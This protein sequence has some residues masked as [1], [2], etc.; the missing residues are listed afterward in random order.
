MH[1]L[2]RRKGVAAASLLMLAATALTLTP[3]AAQA[4]P[5]PTAPAKRGFRLFARS[6]GALTINRVYCGLSSVGNI[7]VDSTNSTTVGGGF[8]PKGTPNQ[9]IFNTGLQLAGIIG[10][11]KATNPWGADTTGAFF[12]DATGFF[13]SGREVAPIYNMVQP[14]DKAAVEAGATDQTKAAKVPTELVDSLN[15]FNPVL[16]GRSS[17]SQGDVW[18]LSWDGD[19]TSVNGRPHPLGI[20]V[21]Q[22]GL[23]WNFP[24]GNQD[25]IYFVY[26]FYNITTTNQ[27]DYVANNVRPEMLPIL[28]AQAQKFQTLNNAAFNITLPAGGYAIN[29]LF[30]SF[31]ADMDVGDA[32]N[33]YASVNLP[34]ALGYAYESDFGTAATQG[35]LFNDASIYGPPF[36]SGVGFVGVKYLKGPTGPGAIQLYSN[37][38]NGTPFSGAVNDP[39][40]STQLFRYLSGTQNTAVGDQ[41][42]S[43]GFNATTDHI[44][45]IN[46]TKPVDMRF[47]QSSTPLT[48]PPGGFG[49]I[50]VAY[51]FAAPVATPG[52]TPPVASPGVTPGDPR[53]LVSA[54]GLTAGNVN[55]VD[56][57]T[58]FVSYGDS[59]GDGKVQQSEFNVVPRSLLG[60][61]LVA[62]Q[63]FDNKFLL[64]F[65]PDAPDFFLIPGDGQVTI[66][67]RP[68]ASET[69]GDPFFQIASQPT[70]TRTDPV[71]GLPVTEANLLY[72]PNYRQFDVEGYRIFRGRVDNPQSLALVQQFDY[73][74]TTIK[75]FAGQVNPDAGCAP[76]LDIT[77]TCAVAFDINS[78]TPAGTQRNTFVE[79]PL[80]GDI[81]QVQ[82][83]G[84]AA[85]ATGTAILIKSDTA[86]GGG[87]SGFPKL[88][89][90]GVPFAFIDHGVRN[91]F[92]YFYSVTAFDLN[93]FQSGPSSLESARITKSVTPV[94]Q[95][96]NVAL[97]VLTSGI[98]GDDGQQ[99]DPKAKFTIDPST[100]R[101]SGP[102]PPTSA[103]SAIFQ[104]LVPALLPAV[105]LTAT[106]DSLEA[107]MDNGTP[108]DC[109][110]T[111]NV[112][113]N[114][115][116]YFVTFNKDGVATQSSTIV[117][118][119]I[120][121][122]AFG[123][124]ETT[125]GLG[126]VA[127]AADPAALARFGVP[128]GFSQFNASV[129]ATFSFTG[130]SSA[131]EN[132]Y[133]RRNSTQPNTSPGGSRWFDGANETV[134]D[135]AY[136]IRVGHLAGV[137]TIFAAF[138]H[139]DADP[140]TAGTQAAGGSGL[141]VCI[142]VTPYWIINFARQAD[143][144]VTWGAGGT[145]AKVR[146]VTD[147][148]NVPFNPTPE[149]SYGFFG[150]AD[151][152]GLVDYHDFDFTN[153][154]HD[155][156]DYLGFCDASD[157][158]AAPVLQLTAQPTIGPVSSQWGTANGA[159]GVDASTMTATGQ[160]FGMYINGQRFI[161]QLTGGQP[162]AAGTKWT[163]RSYMGT[164]TASAATANTTNPE[165][166]VFAPFT[167]TPAVP[168]LQVK[169]NVAKAAEV[170]AAADS[171]LSKVHTVPDPYYV[172]NEF[173]ATTDA[174][175]I[176]FV[177]LPAQAI[178]RIYSSSGV[179]VN[180]IEHNS[181]TFGGSEN[182][183]VRNRN[184]QVV[185]SGVYF[186]HIEA[187]SARKVGR[188]TVVNFAQ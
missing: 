49:S 164:V 173:E 168:G 159:G 180:L 166:Y 86:L 77:T 140:T 9:Y 75:D 38:V 185:A 96:T 171:N 67:W 186:Y 68:S 119:P 43:P 141:S 89:D 41:P 70:V 81:V 149:A 138:P 24:S 52:L 91:N 1:P 131:G 28:M 8:W 103:L 104:P 55:L 95:A 165:G 133:G 15:L 144:E 167:A 143:I 23:G 108:A 33:N 134:D 5:L 122:V 63:V 128:A 150:D 87:A 132:F 22:R 65:A 148:V 110:G 178:I 12:F 184:N 2:L 188:M 182:W 162:P 61:A 7:C 101:F 31:S 19:P 117:V 120:L 27:A 53:K 176:K 50:V 125:A 85:L 13:D 129:G 83:G 154:P 32:G 11:T 136:G 60:K 114:C 169:F 183:N 88:A 156:Q 35:F 121:D 187:G 163:L 98:F 62:Q 123:E 116:K 139:I 76:E 158:D 17:A 179:L 130:R 124:T 105:S 47:F 111:S 80:V 73:A 99:L 106:I 161:F 39:G 16:R 72:D 25:I 78:T 90:T 107:F 59:N 14:D 146:D 44:C 142:Q 10:G 94:A 113:G 93:S 6:L 3:Q 18:W 40:N 74:G 79:V 30:A 46:N 56:R 48:L 174:K 66:V 54:A 177:N 145:I 102:P 57:V 37:T 71:T 118:Q 170:L 112:Q 115:V 153:G 42:C 82:L 181:G 69:A 92:R 109:N 147:H 84:R 100:G 29:S 160:G 21:E 51:I 64:P 137:D 97:P 4:K 155:Y 126:S 127:V 151:G 26:T 58:G 36:F 175:V 45:F 157:V 34:F 152:N 20:V 172:T 135:P